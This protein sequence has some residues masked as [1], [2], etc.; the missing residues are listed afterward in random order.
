MRGLR[1]LGD[2]ENEYQ[3]AQ[4]NRRLGGVETLML[5]TGGDQA[6]ISSSLVRQL[7]QFNGDI[8][9][10]VPEGLAEPIKEAYRAGR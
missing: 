6:G 10:F 8:T 9:P 2:F 1:P 7:L 5:V 3:M 4:V